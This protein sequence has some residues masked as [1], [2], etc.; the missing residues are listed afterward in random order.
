MPVVPRQLLLSGPQPRTSTSSTAIIAPTLPTVP[1]PVASTTTTQSPILPPVPII[2]GLT[3]LVVSTSTTVI[4]SPT[5]V[6]IPQYNHN[7]KRYS[8]HNHNHFFDVYHRARHFAVKS[9]Y[10]TNTFDIFPPLTHDPETSNTPDRERNSNWSSF[11]CGS[12]TQDGSNMSG[13]II[14]L[15]VIGALLAALLAG[16]FIFR[17]VQ[18]PSCKAQ[19]NKLW[20]RRFDSS[21]FPFTNVSEADLKGAQ[22]IRDPSVSYKEKPLPSI[23]P[24]V[25]PAPPNPTYNQ[26]GQY[27]DGAMSGP[28]P[29]M[30][31]AAMGYGYGQPGRASP[32]PSQIQP[33]RM[34]SPAPPPVAYAPGP[35]AYSNPYPQAPTPA[36]GVPAS[37][38]AVPQTNGGKKRVIQTFQ[39]TLPDELDIRDGDWVIVLHAYDDG[40][41]LCECNGRRGVVPLECLDL[42]RPDFR[43]SRRFSSL[44]AIRQ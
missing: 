13:G 29:T 5:A 9:S 24:D 36:P 27:S 1:E 28:Y 25:Y 4:V 40:W 17:R 42:G 8:N 6:L 30:G 39:P 11:Q 19:G 16:A 12:A 18:V 10:P 35:S 37:N 33:Q 38:L 34:V 2:P 32:A 7:Y 22:P 31:A 15:I 3:S 14:A 20:R 44:S 41:G 21:L 23:V 26:F 43:A